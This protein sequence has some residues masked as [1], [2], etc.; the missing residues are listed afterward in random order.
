MSI[1]NL[2]TKQ[3]WRELELITLLS[4]TKNPLYYK[5][6]CQM[7]DCSVLTLQSCIT[8]SVFMEDLG[9][10]FYKDSQFHIH[11]NHLKWLKG[12]L[13]ESLAR[14]SFSSVDVGLVF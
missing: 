4:E 9:K 11:Y 10:L 6:A 12:G 8:N 2:F 1:E 3:Q 7:L 5:D 14:V 13:S